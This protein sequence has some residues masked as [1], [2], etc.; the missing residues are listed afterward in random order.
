MRFIHYKM[1]NSYSICQMQREKTNMTKTLKFFYAMILF[2]SL[3]LVAK[4]IEG[5]E[6]DSDCPQ[7]FNF[8][9]FICKCINNEC[10]KVILQKGYM[11]MKPKIL[12]KRYTRKN[13]FL[14]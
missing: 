9:P 7:I 4:E 13:E 5:C 2:L 8:H 1:I 10:E 11:S 3:F 14:H 12:H 6:D